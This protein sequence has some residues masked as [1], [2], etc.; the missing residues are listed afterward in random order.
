MKKIAYFTP[1]LCL[2]TFGVPAAWTA[3]LD[4]ND[5]S[6]SLPVVA[7]VMDSYE[8][9]AAPEPVD[10]L[11][12]TP[13]DANAE[14]ISESAADSSVADSMEYATPEVN[15]RFFSGSI[16][17][18]WSDGLAN[19]SGPNWKMNQ[20]W[21][22]FQRP[23]KTGQ[24]LDVGYR[25]DA[26]FGTNN[27]QCYGDGGFDGKWG[28][29]GDG[30]AASLYQAYGELSVGN[31]TGKFGKFETL[32]GYE[33]LDSAVN[34]ATVGTLTHTYMYEAEPLT[35]SGALFTWA[36][37][38]RFDVSFGVAAGA[39]NSFSNYYGD[40]GFL[41]GA[42]FKLDE[43]VSVSYA[44]E[45]NQVHSIVGADRTAQSFGYYALGGDSIGDQDE[46]LQMIALE[47]CL[48]DKLDYA[49][50][51]NYG[52]M[53]DRATNTDR[54]SQYGFANY[55][56]YDLSDQLVGALR[57]EYYE[58]KLET[59][60]A[61]GKRHDLTFSV[62]YKPSEHFFVLP[63]IRYDWVDVAGKKDDGTTGAVAV[64]FLF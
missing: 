17:G 20:A 58:D 4:S 14:L 48:T 51:T 28:V 2:V 10:P 54:Y 53:Q 62:V 47:L 23:T 21:L 63:E 45:L 50:V 6:S 49:F 13:T 42:S 1:L 35:H 39:D 34:A 46:Y 29:S 32:L 11:E 59:K 22:T 41:F 25:I 9:E 36:P 37:T 12:Y 61:K 16:V 33:S 18:S 64:G 5:D 57:Y 19:T 52:T 3:D 38:D 44:A 56:T 60:V 7:S 30:Y 24:Q 27:G 31:I 15:E 40:T 26:L 55:L 8:E 43:N